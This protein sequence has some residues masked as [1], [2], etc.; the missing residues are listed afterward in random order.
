MAAANPKD[1]KK[2]VRAFFAGV[3]TFIDF[4]DD[5]Q[6]GIPM[7]ERVEKAAKRMRKRTQKGCQA[8]GIGHQGKKKNGVR[9]PESEVDPS[10]IDVEAE[11]IH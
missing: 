5:T 2:V 1:A 4:L 9:S 7:L 3:S 6:E 8:S 10:V 11:E